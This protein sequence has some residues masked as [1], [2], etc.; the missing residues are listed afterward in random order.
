MISVGG[1]VMATKRKRPEDKLPAGQPTK[2]KP[3]YCQQLI[4]HMAGGNSFE[5]FGAKIDIARATIYGWLELFPE[6]SDAKARGLDK[7]LM[8][9]E[10]VGK[11][12][13]TGAL[14]RV[15]EEV[16]TEGPDG[17]KH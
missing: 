6:F 4:D 13:T 16:T 1:L 3:E 17:K 14:R 8:Y 12:G 7:N 9:W 15:S 10:E 5:S 2:Y 11:A